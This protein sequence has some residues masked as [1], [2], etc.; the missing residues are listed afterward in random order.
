M[1]K[2]NKDKIFISNRSSNPDWIE[3]INKT[4]HPPK[5]RVTYSCIDC[6]KERT[7]LPSQFNKSREEYR[8]PDCAAKERVRDPIWIKNNKLSMVA[9][10]QNLTWRTNN[11]KAMKERA[12]KPEHKENFTNMMLELN[13][14]PDYRMRMK[15]IFKERSENQDWL[16]NI[17]IA[18][19][20][21][22]FWYGHP[23]LRFF[24]KQYCEKWNKNL[25]NRIDIAWDFKSAISGKTKEDNKGRSL[26]RHH[27]YWQEKACCVWDE[28]ADGYYAMINIGTVGKP[29]I[30]K[31]CI[32][33]DPNKFVLLTREE[34][35]KVAGNIKLGLTKLTWI[36]FFE[37]LIEQREQ[38][39]KKCYLTK[40]EY[41]D[42]KNK[43]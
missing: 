9:R 34:H 21:Q 8:C 33:G 14:D 24:R 36:K 12:N 5:P 31:H 1:T 17:L 10:S 29:N 42:Y 40:E 26:S 13:S 23:T 11:K 39:G 22:G 18:T 38:E 32:K 27:V 20:G 2:H 43:R 6:G 25:W 35:G 7:A 16:E 28:D 3:H 30:I 37:D 4:G 15:D 41:E 19:T